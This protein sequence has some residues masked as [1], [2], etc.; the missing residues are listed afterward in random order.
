[1]TDT[2]AKLTKLLDDVENARGEAHRLFEEAMKN[3][4]NRAIKDR[5][6]KALERQAAAMRVA[7]DYTN[8]ERR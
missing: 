3:P 1:M 8:R 7:L 5:M 2:D 6:W 4:G